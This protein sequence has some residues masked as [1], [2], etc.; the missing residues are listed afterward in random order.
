MKRYSKK[1]DYSYSFGA[2]STFEL[3]KKQPDKLLNVLINDKTD[4]SIIKKLNDL[5]IS[6]QTANLEKIVNKQNIYLVGVFK[7]ELNRIN[8]RANHIV[9]VNPTNSGNVG[10]IIR[11]MI[12]FNFKDLVIITPSVDIFNPS[13]IRASMGAFFS[14]NISLFSSIDEYKK[15]TTNKL[16]SFFTDANKSINNT[17]Q[18]DNISLIFGNE[19]SG[20]DNKYKNFSTP[21]IIKTTD[22]VDS[23]NLTTAVSI[24]MYEFSLNR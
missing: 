3:I 16:Y 21:I 20:L 8:K 24:A 2:F 15:N 14:V 7:K 11:S 12:A 10:T 19:Q 13:L 4:K 6:F 17:T 1:L 22:M 9:L 18:K 23:L 5:N